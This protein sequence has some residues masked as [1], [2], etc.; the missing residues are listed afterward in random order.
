MESTQNTPVPVLPGR[1]QASF[2]L[3]RLHQIK[4]TIQFLQ[5]R[6]EHMGHVTDKLR[7]A[8]FFLFHEVEHNLDV[9]N[10]QV[11]YF[12]EN[13]EEYF[14]TP[15]ADHPWANRYEHLLFAK[16]IWEKLR[17]TWMEGM[18]VQEA[19]RKA[20][21]L[22]ID[23][24]RTHE[25]FA[26]SNFLD[27][28]T[29]AW[30]NCTSEEKDAFLSKYF[31]VGLDT[32]TQWMSEIETR[33][34]EDPAVR[35]TMEY[36]SEYEDWWGHNIDLI[37]A[38]LPSDVQ[39]YN[40]A[41]LGRE[42]NHF[43][44]WS[45]DGYNGFHEFFYTF[46]HNK[47]VERLRSNRWEAMLDDPAF[48]IVPL[49]QEE[50]DALDDKECMIC[51]E[52]FKIPA[53]ADADETIEGSDV[54]PVKMHCGHVYCKICITS[55]F[56]GPSAD[57]GEAQCPKC[58]VAKRA[59]VEPIKTEWDI[60]LDHSFLVMNR[61]IDQESKEL[62]GVYGPNA[63]AEDLL[64]CLDKYIAILPSDLIQDMISHIEGTFE[65]GLSDFSNHVLCSPGEV[66]S[67]VHRYAFDETREQR[68][69]IAGYITMRN[70]LAAYLQGDSSKYRTE[71]KRE[72]KIR[73][74]MSTYLFYRYTEFTYNEELKNSPASREED[75]YHD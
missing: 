38:E 9:L 55:H 10:W 62:F 15:E 19:T 49:T 59:N 68:L 26:K 39:Y 70:R 21:V 23:Y 74:H 73:A 5:F 31:T 52:P 58:R 64:R 7:R 60:D 11:T 30:D 33:E 67:H 46:L 2:D 66:L 61:V 28:V 14:L 54:T 57:G 71:L 63:H 44:D 36:S 69:G 4:A 12:S 16:E 27:G 29:D 56:R 37:R 47:A 25:N 35:N 48:S 75:P 8:A 45:G 65:D 53:T 20:Y 40:F 3:I 42:I 22:L 50:L 24:C 1:G 13:T 51:L 72:L 43:E 18:S 32:F 41:D 17:K 6:H 34:V